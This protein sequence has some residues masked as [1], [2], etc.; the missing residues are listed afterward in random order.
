MLGVE[1][2]KLHLAGEQALQ[3]G[4]P[5]VAGAVLQVFQSYNRPV[6]EGVQVLGKAALYDACTNRGRLSAPLQSLLSWLSGLA[7]A[8]FC[9]YT[10]SG[11]LPQSPSRMVCPHVLHDISST[12]IPLREP[13]QD[14]WIVL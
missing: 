1:G 2:A 10:P 12:I 14:P 9:C 3:K 4:L 8:C 6:C 7:A 13:G 5:L 11:I